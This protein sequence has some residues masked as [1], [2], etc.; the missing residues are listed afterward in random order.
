VHNRRAAAV[1]RG[2]RT[3]PRN[4]CI[5]PP[6][7]P[8]CELSLLTECF[9]DHFF[10]SPVFVRFIFYSFIINFVWQR[11]VVAKLDPA[12]STPQKTDCHT[13]DI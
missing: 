7:S 10:C 13:I 2:Y 3:V 11:Q 5:C 1:K 4:L 8:Y 9:M 12:E 6:V